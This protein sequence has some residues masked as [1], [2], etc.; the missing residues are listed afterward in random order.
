[1]TNMMIIY[2]VWSFSVG[3]LFFYYWYKYDM[4]FEVKVAP[5][6]K[7]VLVL[8]LVILVSSLFAPLSAIELYLKTNKNKK[9]IKS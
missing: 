2:I 3:L 1:M 7:K 8:V 5:R 4:P 9:E 6:G